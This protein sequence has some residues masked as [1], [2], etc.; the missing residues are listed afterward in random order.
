M[1]FI[2][3]IRSS[4][5]PVMEPR[6]NIPEIIGIQDSLFSARDCLISCKISSSRLALISAVNL[7]FCSL[8]MFASSR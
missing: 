8:F 5:F 4:I 1:S 3:L 2:S 7:A 6:L